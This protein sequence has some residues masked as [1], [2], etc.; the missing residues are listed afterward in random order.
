MT[1]PR[2]A[3]IKAITNSLTRGGIKEPHLLASSCATAVQEAIS[4]FESVDIPQ[5]P[6]YPDDLSFEDFA[7]PV[8]RSP[9][10]LPQPKLESVPIPVP[11]LVVVPSGAK[12]ERPLAI[13]PNRSGKSQSAGEPKNWE[14]NDLQHYITSGTPTSIEVK[15]ELGVLPLFRSID[16]NEGSYGSGA[17]VTLRYIAATAAGGGEGV[18]LG[19]IGVTHVFTDLDAN[20]LDLKFV[21]T[22]LTRKAEGIVRTR[23]GV[24]IVSR[25]PP[26]NDAAK[27]HFRSITSDMA[28]PA[29]EKRNQGNWA[30]ASESLTDF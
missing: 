26:T 10:S 20:P 15:T 25:N 5:A 22:D 3:L 4:L 18:N 27:M 21:L 11:Q 12:D 17:V 9:I 8:A 16:G 23:S 6:G 24:P 1:I 2:A 7:Q 14:F 19:P 28:R 13:R 29:E 30:E